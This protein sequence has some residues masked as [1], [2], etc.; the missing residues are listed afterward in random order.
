MRLWHRV[1]TVFSLILFCCSLTVSQ[2]AQALDLSTIIQATPRFV[3]VESE[4]RN[5]AD[6]LLGT[7]FGQK[8]DLNNSDIRDFRDLR[9]FYPKLASLIIQNAP[10]EQ[11]EDVLSIPGL[12]ENQ[13][14]RLQA[15]LDK[16][17]VNPPAAVF[18]EGD[19][20]FNP[21]VY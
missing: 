20:R 21:G 14:E 8:I 2:P 4:R 18:N 6:D 9:G 19:E 16:F 13:R 5:V 10:Y 3:A 7:E 15:N 11:V 17:V 1:I 12:S